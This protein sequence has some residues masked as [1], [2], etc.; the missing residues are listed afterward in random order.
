MESSYTIRTRKVL[1]NRLLHRLQMVIEVIHPNLPNVSK[2]Q[3]RDYLSKHYKCKPDSIMLYGFRTA[4]GGGKSTGFAL[5]YDNKD[6]MV[7]IEPTFRL[8]RLG[9]A[10]K[11]GF[12]RKQKKELKNRKKKVRGTRKSKVGAG[13][14]K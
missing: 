6:F 8:T 3:I 9:L 7:K 10:P 13:K 12:G 2:E 4:F 11:R 1:T 14:K 5:I